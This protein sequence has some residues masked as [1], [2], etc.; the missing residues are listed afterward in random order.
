MLRNQELEAILG[1]KSYEHGVQ[2]EDCTSI[3]LTFFKS[4]GKCER[5]TLPLAGSCA[6]TDEFL[7]ISCVWPPSVYINASPP[8]AP[9]PP[10]EEEGEEEA[11][12][13]PRGATNVKKVRK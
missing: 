7:C 2:S 13:G 8:S 11:W 12:Q 5:C 10:E 1:S 9:P 3:P 4:G 6:Q